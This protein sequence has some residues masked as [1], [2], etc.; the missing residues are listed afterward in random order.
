MH[1]VSATRIMSTTI[2]SMT[3]RSIMKKVTLRRATTGAMRRRT[4]RRADLKSSR[5]IS[6]GQY[7]KKSIPAPVCGLR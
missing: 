1:P 4:R 2:R 7:G 3:K 5:V 6:E